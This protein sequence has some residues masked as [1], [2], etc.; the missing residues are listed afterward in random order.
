MR[1]FQAT[2][3]NRDP[4]RAAQPVRPHLIFNKDGMLLAGQARRSMT[5]D[6][7]TASPAVPVCGV[8]LEPG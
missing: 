3:A 7:L 6:Y 2:S 4:R 8:R 5:G 1:R